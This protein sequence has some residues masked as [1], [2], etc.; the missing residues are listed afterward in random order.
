MADIIPAQN[1]S[2]QGMSS[3]VKPSRPISMTRTDQII[4]PIKATFSTR[5]EIAIY[6]LTVFL[7]GLTVASCRCCKWA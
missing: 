2:S 3:L 7:V 1:H 4:F 6:L 5:F